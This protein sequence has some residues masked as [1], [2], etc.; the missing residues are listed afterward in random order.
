[1]LVDIGFLLALARLERY[2][3]SIVE[4]SQ[5]RILHRTS[6]CS[7]GDL[8]EG[9]VPEEGYV[10]DS[11]GHP[12]RHTASQGLDEACLE[13]SAVGRVDP[14]VLDLE[15][16]MDQMDASVGY[17]IPPEA[18]VR[19]VADNSFPA[20]LF[21]PGLDNLAIEAEAEGE[22]EMDPCLDDGHAKYSVS[23]LLSYCRWK[24]VVG[25]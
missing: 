13:P 24:S 12:F 16:Q 17:L 3:P 18:C 21:Q 1:M 25:A 22:R 5:N 23:V 8:E 6:A 9:T 11:D 14:V 10:V 15:N 7:S 4:C 2:A 20:N 19:G